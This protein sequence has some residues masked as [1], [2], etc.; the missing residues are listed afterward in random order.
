MMTGSVMGADDQ[1]LTRVQL[2]GGRQRANK[3][4][5]LTIVVI[6]SPYVRLTV[7]ARRGI[8]FKLKKKFSFLTCRGE[9]SE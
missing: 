9:K 2:M 6:S 1:G 4:G 8:G 3:S 5:S 7:S